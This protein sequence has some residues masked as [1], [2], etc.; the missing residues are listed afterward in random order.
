MSTWWG[1]RLSPPSPRGSADDAGFTLIEVVVALVIL[2]LISAA[3]VPVLILGAK[4]AN[5][6]R[7]NTVAKNL[8]QQRIETM[9]SLPFYVAYQNTGPNGQFYDV[10]DDYYANVDSG[11]L[12]L[13]GGGKGTWVQS[14]SGTG[15]EPS[16]PYYKVSFASL[17]GSTG[18][19][20][21]VYT[22]FLTAAQP[23]PTPVAAS[24]LRPNATQPL[25][26]PNYNSAAAGLD[27]PPS[28]L[29]GVTVTTSWTWG[30]HPHS[31]S[32]Y[33][34]IADN[35]ANNTLIASRAEATALSVSS[36]DTDGNQLTGLLGEVKID[37]NLANTSN[38]SAQAT[39]ASLEQSGGASAS[40]ASAT[41]VSPPNP[42]GSTGVTSA[43]QQPYVGTYGACGWGSFGP[44]DVSDASASTAGGLPV[45]P[46]DVGMGSSPAAFVASHLKANSGGACAGF[47]FSNL[48]KSTDTP[49]PAL[50]LP[51][52]GPLV[53]VVDNTGS[54]AEVSGTASVNALNAPGNAGAVKATTGVAFATRVQLFPGLPFVPTGQSNCGSGGESLCGNGLVNV[55]LTN[56]SLVCASNSGT[57]ATA[58][59]SGY[60]TYWTATGWKTVALSWSSSSGSTTDPLAA[61]DL[62]QTVTTYGGSAVPLSAYINSWSTSRS[63][64]QGADGEST[65]PAVVAITTAN[66]RA[67]DPSSSVGLLL[68]K[69]SCLAVDNR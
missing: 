64:V 36:S 55:F 2:G 7:L 65:I 30:G 66:T 21:V 22:Q 47:R 46:S 52:G 24:L 50:Q 63:I 18:F 28:L 42:A 27:S 5:F 43:G 54:S 58:A 60:L 41:V 15:H 10:L 48:T 40:G 12:N 8:A 19:S 35:G 67:G 9:R 17:P 69:L 51:A 32:T 1:K 14:G 31:F 57:T 61:V 26:A 33:T 53:Q 11:V 13:P 25:A 59:Y 68:G 20:Q 62:S 23:V 16:G 3:L 37:G 29:L 49:D 4:A 39:S 34:Q 45:A 56:A 6:G 44:T 38:A